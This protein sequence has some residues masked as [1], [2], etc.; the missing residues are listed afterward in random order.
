MPNLSIV[1][2]CFNSQATLADCLTAVR[3][4]VYKDF[5]IIVV[6]DHS[7]DQTVRIAKGFTD[8]IIQLDKNKGSGHARKAGMQ[9]CTSDIICFIDSD[10]MI[11]PDTLST[12]IDFLNQHPSIDAV[13]GLLT[14]DSPHQNY[15]SQYKNLY[16]HYIFTL[17]PEK[18]TFLFGSI[19]AIRKDLYLPN[20]TDLRYTPDTESGQQLF[21]SGKTI[22]FLKDLEV[23]HLKRYTALTLLKNDFRIPFSWAKLFI[24]FNGWQQLGKNKTGFAHASQKQLAS[25]MIVYPLIC[26]AGAGF[27]FNPLNILPCFLLVIWLVLNTSFF[28]F[29]FRERGVVFLLAS[30]GI[31]F[32]DHLVM[33]IG[34]ICGF[35]SEFKNTCSIK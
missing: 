24:R 7:S 10:I 33:M 25:V 4:S 17:L 6:D 22:A 30:I 5:E 8:K 11:K 9:L 16:M 2:P 14:K 29:L 13:T 35:L 3:A 28:R 19:C 27:F 34:I 23:T 18:V 12:I 32:L 15:F 31:T 20:N 1:I 26:L 21:A